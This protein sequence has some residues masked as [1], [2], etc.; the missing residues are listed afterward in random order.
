MRRALLVGLAV[1]VVGA[2]AIIAPFALL[3]YRERKTER[4]WRTVD[5]GPTDLAKRYPKEGPNAAAL[6]LE[7]LA[8]PL[9]IDLASPDAPGRIHPPGEARESLKAIS[10][11][12]SDYV[13]GQALAADDRIDPP[14]KVLLLFLQEHE[15]E[16]DA[17]EAAALSSSPRWEADPTE[18]EPSPL[19]NLV[20]HLSLQRLLLARSL[21]N[22][23]MG[24]DTNALAELEASFRIGEALAQRHEEITQI[25]A[26]AISR[27]RA[28][29]LRKTEAVPVTWRMRLDPRPIWRGFA[30]TWHLGAWRMAKRLSGMRMEGLPLGRLWAAEYSGN[31]AEV[32]G[33]AEKQNICSFTPAIAKKIT[34]K[35]FDFTNVLGKVAWVDQK[36]NLYRVFRTL[37]DLEGTEKILAAREA[38]ERAGGAWPAGVSGLESSVC[39]GARWTYRVN[40]DGTATISFEGRLEDWPNKWFTRLSLVFTVSRQAPHS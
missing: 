9:G 11:D 1:I 24:R 34:A 6:E 33:E 29:V 5:P 39:P 36:E 17:L 18:L 21:E 8:A 3:P 25:V 10:R 15:S 4:A 20:G 37:L 38:R 12:N 30:A 27:L 32:V 16:I 22:L 19:P 28:G 14:P 23:R 13:S 35:S 2:G 31:L 7:R 26:L 40:P